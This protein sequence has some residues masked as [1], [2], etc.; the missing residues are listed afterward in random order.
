[1]LFTALHTTSFCSLGTS[2]DAV[3]AGGLFQGCSSTE[4]NTRKM[5][6]VATIMPIAMQKTV[7]HCVSV[8][9]KSKREMKL[10]DQ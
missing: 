10:M 7:C 5:S 2:E 6:Y 3:D 9:Y 4:P 1:M 8:C